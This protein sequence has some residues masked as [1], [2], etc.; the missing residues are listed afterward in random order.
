MA[1]ISLTVVFPELPVIA[2]TFPLFLFLENFPRDINALKT[3]LTTITLF[4]CFNA[5]AFE[6]TADAPFLIASFIN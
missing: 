1:S 2:I 6:I 4:L 3:S 5:G